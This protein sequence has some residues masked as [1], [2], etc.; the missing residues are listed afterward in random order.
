MQVVTASDE[1]LS[2]LP[3][4]WTP[5]RPQPP[6]SL[7]AASPE[8]PLYPDGD[9]Q[10]TAVQPLPPALKRGVPPGLA[11]LLACGVA[12]HDE[13]SSRPDE[14]RQRREG[15]PGATGHSHDQVEALRLE[16]QRVL[17]IRDERSNRLTLEA[18]KPTGAAERLSR[19]VQ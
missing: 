5:R 7:R 13:T 4:R 11:S 15:R 14:A 8:V 17:E 19:G 1:S 6:L 10:L 3:A 16:G 12:L 18:R 9:E 2:S